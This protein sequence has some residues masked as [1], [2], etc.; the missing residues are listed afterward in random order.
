LTPLLVLV[1]LLAGLATHGSITAM[2][3]DGAVGISSADVDAANCD[4]TK[5]GKMEPAD[6]ASICAAFADLARVTPLWHP[7]MLPI[8]RSADLSA[9]GL[10]P[11]P[12]PTP[13]RA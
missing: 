10:T 1:G 11:S 7:S 8:W 2:T 9:D 12:T 5:A 6:C 4:M 13:P 3:I